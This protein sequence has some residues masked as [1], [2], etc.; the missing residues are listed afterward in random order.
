[1]NLKSSFIHART[2][3]DSMRVN[4]KLSSM[5]IIQN[6]NLDNEYNEEAFL[7]PLED[8]DEEN[9]VMNTSVKTF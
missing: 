4:T 3:L 2:E 6:E 8:V 1:M 7:N 9:V 5:M